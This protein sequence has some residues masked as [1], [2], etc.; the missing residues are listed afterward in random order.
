MQTILA[1]LEAL[2]RSPLA[3]L[4]ITAEAVVAGVLVAVG[5][6]PADASSAAA[7]AVFPLGSYFDLEQSLASGS[8]WAFVAAAAAFGT[9]V[10]SASLAA[11]LWLADG[12]RGAFVLTWMRTMRVVALA[13]LLLFPAAVFHL[14]G[15]VLRYAPFVALGGLA[16][17]F[18]SVVLVRRALAIDAG[19]PVRSAALPGFGGFLAYGYLVALAGA[20]LAVLGRGSALGAGALVAFSGPIHALVLLGWREQTKSA[21]QPRGSWVAGTTGLACVVLLGVSLFDRSLAAPEPGQPRRGKLM[22][23]GGVDS[24]STSGALFDLPRGTL[25]FDPRRTIVLSY[26]GVEG[27]Y[28]A[29]DTRADLVEIARAVARQLDDVEHP[30]FLLGHSQAALIVDRIIVEGLPLPDSA[31]ALA[32]PPPFPPAV[33]IPPSG[34]HAPGR[35]GGD[36][37]RAFSSLVDA[38][39]GPRFDIDAPA[40]PTNLRPVVAPESPIPRLSVWAVVD[41]VWLDTD[42]RRPGEVNVVALTDHVGVTRNGYAFETAEAFFRGERVAGHEVSW[43]GFLVSTMRYTFEPWRP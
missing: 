14:T 11:T 3:F 28:E 8:G 23:L 19:R 41:S 21:A 30:R 13:P 1:G 31:V 25:G 22:L 42:W 32:G 4:P 33:S 40:S 24:T 6:F 26:L 5:A 35:P 9:L 39:G 37:A 36:A 27:P 16:G 18:A 10:R 17:V 12:A 38:L 15:Y 7:A 34:Q 20:A 43:Q 2:R 29:R